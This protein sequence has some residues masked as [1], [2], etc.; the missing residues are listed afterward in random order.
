[1]PTGIEG[2]CEYSASGEARCKEYEMSFN[3]TR[4]ILGDVLIAFIDW[5][6]P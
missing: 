3:D 1:M 4:Y 5:L 6:T 2:K